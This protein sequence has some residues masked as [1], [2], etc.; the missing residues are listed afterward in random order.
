MKYTSL[1]NQLNDI[2]NDLETSY[3]D[4]V[5]DKLRDGV[6]TSPTRLSVLANHTNNE[7]IEKAVAMAA[8]KKLPFDEWVKLHAICHHCG[9]KGH[10]HP[11]CPK[12]I[13]QVKSG[14]IKIPPKQHPSPCGLYAA[15]PPGW[16]ATQHPY[17][18]D[19]KAKAFLSAFQALFTKE[20]KEEKEDTEHND[21]V[22]ATDDNED[23]EDMRNFFLMVGS[24]KE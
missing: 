15:C 21:D 7:D 24:L 22:D 16:P 14:Q 3:L 13:K 11:H 18:K 1:Q 5:G 9:E 4:L 23:E 19:P 10:I 17:M 20:D 12:Y 8:M 2:L 6:I